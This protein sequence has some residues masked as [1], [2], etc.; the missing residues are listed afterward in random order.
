MVDV[1]PYF[2]CDWDGQSRLISPMMMLFYLFRKKIHVSHGK[3]SKGLLS[4]NSVGD[5]HSKPLARYTNSLGIV[6][7]ATTFRATLQFVAELIH[8]FLIPNASLFTLIAEVKSDII[9]LPL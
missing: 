9:I 5:F 3:K 4:L 6:A 2:C 1:V 7:I 8:L